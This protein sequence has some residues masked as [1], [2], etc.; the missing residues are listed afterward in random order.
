MNALL[1]QA[2]TLPVDPPH[3]SDVLPSV[4]ATLNGITTVLLIA[5]FVLIRQ[6]KWRAHG[7]TMIAATACSTLFLAGYLLHKVYHHDLKI[8]TRFPNLSDAWRY[9]YWFAILLPHLVLAVVM[10]PFIYVGLWRAYKREWLKHKQINRF[11]IWIW[12]YVSITGV[13]IYYLLYHLFPTLNA[14]AV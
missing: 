7:I 6:K 11:T 13:L 10:L 2:S 14:Q 4:N 8:A 1:A 12:L 9:T 5:G 3:W